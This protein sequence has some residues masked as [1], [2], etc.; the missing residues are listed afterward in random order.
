MPGKPPRPL[1]EES[2]QCRNPP[3]ARPVLV[4]PGDQRRGMGDR[5][6]F[7]LEATGLSDAAVEIH[8]ARAPEPGGRILDR[9][10]HAR[11]ASRFR[12]TLALEP[13]GSRRSG[14]I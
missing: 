13:D 10:A 3:R 4:E 11:R 2:R 5:V 14:R 1:L 8:K 7:A 12:R 6:A 9:L